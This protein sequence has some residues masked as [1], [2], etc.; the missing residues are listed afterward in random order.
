M[1]FP[2]DYPYSPP[3]IRFM[4]KVWHPNVYEVSEYTRIIDLYF[5]SLSL[6]PPPPSFFLFSSHRV[7][8][9]FSCTRVYVRVCSSRL[10]FTVPFPFICPALSLLS[11]F[12]H[13]GCITNRS[14]ALCL[15]VP[16]LFIFHPPRRHGF[17]NHQPLHRHF[18]RL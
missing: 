2:P 18:Q 8:I 5:L 7:S 6:S 11:L 3:S 13:R 14:L 16:P 4:T 12:N 15:C 10:S 17:Y 9:L 1:K